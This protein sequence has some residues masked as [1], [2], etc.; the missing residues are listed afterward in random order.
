M[1]SCFSRVRLCVT[2]WTVAH[3]APLSMILSK[4]EYRRGLPFPPLG[5]LSNPGKDVQPVSLMS[6]AFTGKFFTSS[7]TWESCR[8]S[9]GPQILSTSREAGP[10]GSARSVE[11]FA[12]L[13]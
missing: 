5:N 2:P 6:P 13:N 7:A 12:L 11:S 1:L 4:Q 3:H 9:K 8:K 10:L